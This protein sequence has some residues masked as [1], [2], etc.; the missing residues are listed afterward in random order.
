[1][2]KSK[3]RPEV[4]GETGYYCREELEQ[5]KHDVFILG[6][7]YRLM[8]QSCGSVSYIPKSSLGVLKVKRTEQKVIAIY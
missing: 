3:I 5:I 4:I 7:R 8:C 2:K 1:M 6:G